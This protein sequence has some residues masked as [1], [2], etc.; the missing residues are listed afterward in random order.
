[1]EDKIKR[2]SIIRVIEAALISYALLADIR[3]AK[4]SEEI[5]LSNPFWKLVFLLVN[6]AASSVK[7]KGILI[8]LLSYAFYILLC[9]SG[10]VF[11]KNLCVSIFS[12]LLSFIQI[13]GRGVKSGMELHGPKGLLGTHVQLLKTIFMWLG[14]FL[15]YELLFHILQIMQK[16]IVQNAAARSTIG[17]GKRLE[18]TCG[19]TVPIEKGENKLKAYVNSWA[20]K[21]CKAMDEHPLGFLL[22]FWGIQILI[23]YP[24]AMT[25]DNW[26]QLTQYNGMFP[27]YS[28]W[29]PFHTWLLGSFVYAGEAVIST[30]VG[31][32]AYVVMQYLVLCFVF[33]RTICIMKLL[34]VNRWFRILSLLVYLFCPMLCGYVGTVEKDVLY[35]GLFVLMICEMIVL[36][37]G[38][39][40]IWKN[41]FILFI[42]TVMVGLFRKNGLYVLV[43]TALW[44][45]VEMVCIS[46]R[47]GS[48][49]HD[50]NPKE[51]NGKF[52]A[53]PL[54]IFI[55]AIFTI[56]AVNRLLCHVYEIRPGSY[57]EA[58]SLPVQQTARY[59]R[60]HSEELS[61]EEWARLAEI[62]EDSEKLGDDYNAVLADATKEKLPYD[63]EKDTMQKYVRLWWEF[64][65]KDPAVYLEAT[66][67]QN[68]GL[69]C[70][71]DT[72]Y[73]YFRDFHMEGEDRIA[74][75]EVPFL[76]EAQ[77]VTCFIYGKMQSLPF[78]GV[79]CDVALYVNLA[80][81][82][83]VLAVGRNFHYAMLVFLPYVLSVLIVIA[84]PGIYQLTR[85]AF[86]IVYGTP[87]LFA[88]SAALT[89]EDR[90]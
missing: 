88:F 2:I 5:V 10:F 86:P 84:G 71:D 18:T 31:L 70:F 53:Y 23:R 16:K 63:F 22:F 36:L 12:I 77:T 82:L 11:S 45:F 19:P 59:V 42:A 37:K 87:L 54:T 60:T 1:M 26:G 83:C 64:F 68:A 62:F 30:N 66:L 13:F 32:F 56:C 50:S 73:R 72:N 25:P 17:E 74:F 52:L 49:Q 85:Y 33:A 21:C 20:A 24:G 39:E 65:W 61:E 57:R 69:F 89:K 67:E 51:L 15:L 43:P 8:A 35:S 28:H 3:V 41:C 4:V 46:I 44:L 38:Y 6:G 90:K 9:K 27:M 81:M 47:K 76:Q 78:L 34:G 55:L 79:F 29:P 75:F 58:L 14:F 48:G 40:T 7:G 80:L